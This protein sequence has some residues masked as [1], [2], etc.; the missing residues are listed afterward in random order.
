MLNRDKCSFSDGKKGGSDLWR[1]FWG[2]LANRLVYMHFYKISVSSNK[3]L[4]DYRI[5]M[6]THAV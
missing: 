1:A 2:F 6:H 4:K 3:G 5:E